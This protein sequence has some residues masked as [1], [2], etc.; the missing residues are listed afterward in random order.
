MLTLHRSERADALVAPLAAVLAEPPEDP[1]ARDV[2]AVPTR[3]V[4]R[5]L[6][7]RLSHHLGA[8]ADGEAGLCANVDLG[9]PARLVTQ[10]L[11]S[12]LDLAPEEDPWRPERLTWALLEVVDACAGEAW[13][14]ALG[15]H[16]GVGSDDA[17]RRGRRLQAAQHLGRLFS[18]YAAQRPAMLRSWAVGDDD[19]GAG[20]PVPAD[21]AWQPEL[22]RRLRAHLGTPSPAERLDDAVA[23][24]AAE[25]GSVDLPAR[26]SV[27]G[28]TRLAEDQLTVLTALARHRAVHLWLPHPSPALWARV[29]EAGTAS[30][31]RRDRRAVARHPM[32]ASMARDATEL[33]TRLAHRADV[34]VHPP[35]AAPPATLLGRL[36]QRLRDDDA[37]SPPAPHD[38]ADRSIQVHACHGRARQVEVLREAL[39]GLFADDPTLE[40]RD[41]V[42]LC[43][44]IEAVAP[45]VA[46]TFGAAPE[47]AAG[48]GPGDVHPGRHLRVRLADRALRQTNPVLGL[49]A[50]VLELADGRVTASDVVDLAGSEPVRHRFGF[51]DEALDRIRA[52][53]AEAGV[54]WGEDASRRLRF[55]LAV[56]QGTWDAGLNRLLL[57]VAMAEEDHRYVGTA[58]P[59]DDVGST[60]VDLA[61]RLAE[62][63][64]RLATVL[65][66]LDGARPAPAWLDDLDRALDLLAD[67]PPAESWQLVEARR[68]LAEV[69]SEATDPAT[70]PVELR[71]ADVRALLSRRLRGRPTRAGFRTGALTMCSLEPMRA[72]P[73]R[74]VVLLG[75]DDGAFPRG[76]GT[77]GDD[78]LL[79]DP[80]VGERDRRSEDRQLFLDAVAAAGE[81]L[82]VLY[83]G[84][85]E[86]TGAL[87]PPAVPVGELL[88]ALDLTATATDGGPVRP[89]VVVR[90]PL[91]PVD[92]RNFT[93]G[94]LGRP[95][96]F[97]FDVLDHRAALAGRGER[98][99]AL[100]FLPSPLAPPEDGPGSADGG[101]LDLGEL[102]AAVEHPVR[103][104]LR[105]RLGV[106]VPRETRDLDDALPLVLDP[107]QKWQVG[108]ALL[109]AALAGEDLGRVATAE[110]LRGVVPPAQVGAAFLREMREEIAPLT[111]ATLRRRPDAPAESVEV[112]LALPDGRELAGT[113]H[114]VHDGVLVRPVY[115]KLSAKYRLRSWVALLALAAARPGEPVHAVTVGRSPKTWAGAAVSRL[116]APPAD[117][118]LAELARLVDLRDRTLREPLPL[119][120]AAACAYAHHRRDDEP[121]DVALAAAAKEWTGAYE[122]TDDWHELAWGVGAE[123]S[124]A[125]GPSAPPALLAPPPADEAAWWPESTRFGV[126]ARRLWAPVLDAE[127]VTHE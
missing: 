67:A 21:L 68:V 41:V 58:L 43:P 40:P 3:G 53:T 60:D 31:R 12:V 38:P 115:S 18:S 42:V 5:W 119:P 4:E 72:V 85:D 64:D 70:G 109:G 97:S 11:S 83:T 57:G 125:S 2:V 65:R 77:D 114:G 69:R 32:L 127:Q 73:H 45:L 47:P 111:D 104:F 30:V 98:V 86:R 94:A 37:A 92:E 7:Q 8:G 79:R 75:M 101:V 34:D 110:W 99:G 96:P 24:L 89:H 106:Q 113:L 91:Q 20:R 28:P 25:P 33:Q 9:S 123:L 61:G 105:G 76:S 23:R 82:L 93:A 122:Q 124:R 52:W 16:L 10:V 81:H 87:R 56:P 36:Q 59:L 126:L 17:V 54:R 1:F 74:V 22:W 84:A 6:A 88:D 14:S 120:V 118:A 117:E 15:R 108:D 35:A 49:L 102:V 46:A 116:V 48:G 121:E 29:V 62:L 100:P 71:L 26:L 112:R 13:C 90:H 80:L 39:L 63:V 19:D 103:A 107:L 66:A 95:G 50:R 44:D 55:G 27:F 51:D 78:V